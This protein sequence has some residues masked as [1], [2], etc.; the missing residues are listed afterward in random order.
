MRFFI[1]I[2]SHGISLKNPYCQ[3]EDLNLRRL[4]QSTALLTA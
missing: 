4:N 1:V 2:F 3:R